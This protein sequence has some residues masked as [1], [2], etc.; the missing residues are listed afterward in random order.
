M[1]EKQDFTCIPSCDHMNTILVYA[2]I[3]LKLLIMSC[4]CSPAPLKDVIFIV[5]K[6]NLSK[7]NNSRNILIFQN[8]QSTIVCI[9]VRVTPFWHFLQKI[10][11]SYVQ[12]TQTSDKQC[13]SSS[14]S[15]NVCNLGVL[16]QHVAATAPVIASSLL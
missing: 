13:S 16:Y 4:Y 11:R 2:S 15:S 7:Q 8:L 12:I 9:P 1:K 3:E 14:R 10:Q 6:Q 5:R